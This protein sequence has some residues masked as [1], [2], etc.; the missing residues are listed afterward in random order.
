MDEFDRLC[1]EQERIFKRMK[2]CIMVIGVGLI[3]RIIASIMV[4][5]AGN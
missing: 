5:C 4:L 2:I 3:I 1:V